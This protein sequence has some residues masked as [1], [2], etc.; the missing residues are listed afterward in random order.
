[1]T[2]AIQDRIQ[3]RKDCEDTLAMLLES[4]STAYREGVARA[5]FDM[6]SDQ[7]PKQPAEGLLVM[8]QMGAQSFEKQTIDFGIHRGKTY[9]EAP[10]EYLTWLADQSVALQAYLRSERGRKRIAESE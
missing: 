10:I 4:K 9:G 8:G 3:G 5:C 6:F 2:T 7:L 1:M